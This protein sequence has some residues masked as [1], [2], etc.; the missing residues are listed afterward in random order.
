MTS[1]E[2]AEKL[3]QMVRTAFVDS[4]MQTPKEM[5]KAR[6]ELLQQMTA[7]IEKARGPADDHPRDWREQPDGHSVE[8]GIHAFL[9]QMGKV[10]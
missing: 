3:E 10:T 2:L 4:F 5:R 9:D 6:E 7:E 1:R 8:P